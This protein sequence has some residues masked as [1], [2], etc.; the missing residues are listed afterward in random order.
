[1]AVGIVISGIV[2]SGV[3]L[4]GNALDYTK[5]TLFKGGQMVDIDLKQST[6]IL[7]YLPSTVTTLLSPAAALV[8][9]NACT[10]V[11]AVNK[12]NLLTLSIVK[13]V[14]QYSGITGGGVPEPN[15]QPIQNQTPF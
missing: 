9:L 1:M 8:L 2:I 12:P 15:V 13:N 14:L 6:I 10:Y 5:V 3:V 7:N 4:T 11:S